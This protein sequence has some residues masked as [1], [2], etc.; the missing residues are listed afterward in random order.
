MSGHHQ[1]SSTRNPQPSAPAGATGRPGPQDISHPDASLAAETEALMKARREFPGHRI[2]RELTPG[3]AVYVARSRH[4]G[5]RP[6]TAVTPDL[7][8]LLAALS[9]ASRPDAAMNH[10]E[11][12]RENAPT[13]QHT[14]PPGEAR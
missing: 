7:P 3:R 6:H 4:P 10:P 5:A 2:W 9:D 14:L 8:E 13:R 11:P 12:P 1:P